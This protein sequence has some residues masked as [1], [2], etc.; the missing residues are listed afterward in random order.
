[1]KFILLPLSFLLIASCTQKGTYEAI[2]HGQKND[3]QPLF[4]DEYDRCMEKHDMQYDEYEREREKALQ[5]APE[6]RR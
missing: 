6:D 4:G 1:M 3:C 2:Q 5:R